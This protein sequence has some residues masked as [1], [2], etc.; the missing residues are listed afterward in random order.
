MSQDMTLTVTSADVMIVLSFVVFYSSK[1]SIRVVLT[2][3]TL[4]QL[5]AGTI[6]TIIT[7]MNQS[8]SLSSIVILLILHH[9]KNTIEKARDSR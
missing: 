8:S 4:G 2:G 1:L 6:E 5:I 7:I 3:N 9:L